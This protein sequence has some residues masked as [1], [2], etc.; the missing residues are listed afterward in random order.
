[1]SARNSRDLAP[2]DRSIITTRIFDAPRELVFDAWSDPKHLAEWWGPTGFTTTTRSFAMQPGGVWRF[3]MHGPDGRDYENRITYDEIVRP[4][5]LVYR[6]GGG[7]DVEPVQFK[8]VVTFEEEGGKTRLTMR[9]VFPSAAERDRVAKEYGAI[10]GAKQ[11]LERLAG[12][13]AAMAKGGTAPREFVITRAFA[14]PRELV[15]QAWTDAEALAQWWG[16]KGC[17]IR[18]VKLDARPGGVFHYAMQ[19]KPGHDMWGKFV[20][21]EM[22]KP[23]RLVFINSFSDPEGGSPARRFPNSGTPGR[24]KS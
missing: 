2:D 22:V 5:R 20:Y 21:R 16:P 8:V 9:A 15:W 19:F 14:A 12:Y 10:E 23:E 6:H 17:T 7:D 11:T 24:L 3:V 18:I 1:M 4:E 13:V